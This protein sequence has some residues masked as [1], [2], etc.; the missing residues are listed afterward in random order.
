MS[1]A[2]DTG[3]ERTQKCVV[4]GV[5]V[6]H[7]EIR[8]FRAPAPS[9][10]GWRSSIARLVG[11]TVPEADMTTASRTSTFRHLAHVH[12]VEL[13][14]LRLPESSSGTTVSREL[15][16]TVT[17]RSI[18]ES[19]GFVLIWRDEMARHGAWFHAGRPVIPIP[20]SRP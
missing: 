9:F 14:I 13:P 20:L 3:R 5:E 7:E 1:F 17:H 18:V 19:L 8:S 15:C 2:E 6:E 11:R 16:F 10:I 12:V 4:C